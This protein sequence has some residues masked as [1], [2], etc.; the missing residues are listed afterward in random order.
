M[1]QAQTALAEVGIDL[2]ALLSDPTIPRVEGNPK[3]GRLLFAAPEGA[4]LRTRKLSM[5]GADRKPIM[6]LELALRCPW[7][8]W[9]WLLRCGMAAASWRNSRTAATLALSSRLRVRDLAG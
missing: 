9:L 2:D 3:K 4:P 1:G 7:P 8:R 6:V 5:V